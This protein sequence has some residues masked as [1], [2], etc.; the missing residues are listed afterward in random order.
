VSRRRIVPAVVAVVLATTLLAGCKSNVGAAAR[1]DGTRISESDVNQYVSPKGVASDVAAQANGQ[2]PAPRSQIL[3]YLVQA[4]LFEHVLAH[5][6]IHPTDGQLEAQH[7]AAAQTLLQTQLAGADLDRTLDR[8]LPR[9]GIRSS[10]RSRFLRTLELE[11]LII[12]DRKLTQFSQLLAVVQ[13]ARVKVSVSPR[14][15]TW[16]AKNLQLNGQPPLPS[17]VTQQPVTGG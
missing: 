1:V 17:F 12:R 8:Q 14:Y 13:Q 2:Q 5:F 10:F 4:Q 9:A 7:D 16:D 15:G 11:Y 6:G 3:H